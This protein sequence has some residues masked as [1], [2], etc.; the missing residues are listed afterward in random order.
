MPAEPDAESG[1]VELDQLI[2]EYAIIKDRRDALDDMLEARKDRILMVMSEAGARKHK[3]AAGATSF[4]RRRSFLIHDI[5]KL[6]KL[7]PKRQLAAL[8]RMTA[9]TYDAAK[10]EGIPLDEAVTV[11]QSE[12]LTVSRAK[13]KE[14]NKRRMAYIEESRKQ[15]EARIEAIREQLRA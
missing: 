14:A 12:S 11:G 15:A 2:N 7:L 3:C 4:T 6:T 10:A 1:N 5:D 9:D 8:A 13:T